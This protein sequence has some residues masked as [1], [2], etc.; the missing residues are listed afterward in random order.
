MSNKT[1]TP[2]NTP[3]HLD[4]NT[5]EQVEL[6][7][8]GEYILDKAINKVYNARLRLDRLVFMLIIVSIFGI[9]I[10]YYPPEEDKYKISIMGADLSIP[11]QTF[12]II[13]AVVLTGIFTVIGSNLIDY[14]RKRSLLDKYAEKIFPDIDEKERNDILVH[15]SFYEFM[16]RL[17]TFIGELRLPASLL[18]LTIFYFSHF[19]AI[20][21]V[22]N[23]F[24]KENPISYVVSVALVLYFF[25]LYKTFVRSI[26]KTKDKLGKLMI[27]YLWV[28]LLITFLFFIMIYFIA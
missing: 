21:Q 4:G 1:E 7:H 13:I 9:I 19:V 28:S 11:R 12:S 5:S 3:S 27:K 16:Y 8:R 22:F 14:I 10:G 24:G 25:Q 26:I 18:I 2:S 17:D 6:R 15:T 23:C 20:F